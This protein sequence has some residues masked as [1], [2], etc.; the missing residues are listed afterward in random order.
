MATLLPLLSV[1]FFMYHWNFFHDISIV[2]IV[3]SV[4]SAHYYHKFSHCY[5]VIHDITCI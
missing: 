1:K 2:V 4:I 3:V 5:Q